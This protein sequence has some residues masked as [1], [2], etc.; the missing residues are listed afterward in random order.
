M[1]ALCTDPMKSETV[2]IEKFAFVSVV[3][4]DNVSL[5]Y[6]KK[7]KQT[8]VSWVVQQSTDSLQ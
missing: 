7:Q 1:W 3:W 6:I 5:F 4:V 2:K 8:E